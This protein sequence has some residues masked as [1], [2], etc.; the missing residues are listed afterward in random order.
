M[1]RVF[2]FDTGNRLWKK[3]KRLIWQGIY[4]L[5]Y[6]RVYSVILEYTLIPGYNGVY[7][8]ILLY[9]GILGYPLIPGYAGVYSGILLYQGI[10][11]I[12]GYTRVY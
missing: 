2:W 11:G 5:G 3:L 7:S 4:I 9:Q 10:L 1:I 12:L 6:T 8:G